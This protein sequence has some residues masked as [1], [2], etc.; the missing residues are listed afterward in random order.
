MI[1]G[2]PW[3]AKTSAYRVLGKALQRLHKAFPENPLYCDVFQCVLNPKAI[4]MGQLY[5]QFDGVTHEWSDGIV[6]INYRNFSQKVGKPGDRKWLL[7]DG[8]VDAI[9]IENMNTVLDDNKKLCL[10]SGEMLKLG[11]GC[12]MMFEPMDLEVASPATVSRVGVIFMEPHLIGW[13]PLVVSW[14]QSLCPAW[15][16]AAQKTTETEKAKEEGTAEAKAEEETKDAARDGA[17]EPQSKDA[18]ATNDADI[19]APAGD[20]EAD[21][22]PPLRFQATQCDHM[23]MLFD[24]LFDPVVCFVSKVVRAQ[25]PALDQTL[26]NAM[27]RLLQAVC[28]EQ[29]DAIAAVGK[30]EEKTGAV[31][32]AG[33][34]LVSMLESYFMF[35]VI[36]AV[37]V[38]VDGDG[39]SEFN[40]FMRN[41]LN[42]GISYLDEFPSVRTG[43]CV[44]FDA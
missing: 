33:K 42:S 37:G 1:V 27:I 23:L 13:R 17:K 24:W 12:S 31:D 19:S 11:E 40:Q 9:W 35:A 28:Q 30:G 39:R 34:L 38:T 36:W 18:V 7:F 14:L 25:I 8:P 20:D 22:A 16:P 21:Q 29:W 41:F 26:V 44:L 32:L 6:A 10:E 15:K 3:G 4:T 2:L 43:K 5:G